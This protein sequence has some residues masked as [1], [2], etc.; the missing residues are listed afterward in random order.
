M[1][2]PPSVLRI[3]SSYSRIIARML[4]LQERDLPA[5]LAGTGLPVDILLPGDET[6]LSG[7]QQIQIL[8]NGHRLIHLPGFGLAMG[9]H[10]GPASHG[11]IGY[12]S[13]CSPDLESALSAFAEFLPARLPLVALEIALSDE[14]LE[15]G[16]HIRAHAPDYIRQGMEESFAVSVQSV[17]ETILR[18]DVTEAEVAFSH[19]RPEYAGRY[20]E[21]LHGCYRFDSD[22][23]YYR[24]PATLARVANSGGDSEAFRLTR[25][26]CSQLLEQ[27]PAAAR[28]VSDRVRTLLLS[29]PQGDVSEE[30]IAKAMFVS[31]RTLARRLE[32]EGSGY[33]EIRARV[34][35]ELARQSLRQSGQSV[36]SIAASLGYHDS[37]AFRKAFKRWTGATPQAYRRRI[38]STMM[39][40]AAPAVV[41][42]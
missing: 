3:N 21:L 40:E 42:D 17:V 20:A 22:R 14:W 11:P 27:Q 15:C 6:H 33:R 5:L 31:R 9:Q 35:S 34:L 38:S 19:P 32:Q 13:L 24:L 23:V 37:S 26:L 39:D 8:A 36:E 2:Q 18:R 25:D 29:Q 4:R 10:L 28:S 30:Q 12:L 16:Y 1:E 41:M 7:E